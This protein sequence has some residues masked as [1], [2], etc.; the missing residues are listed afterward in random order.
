MTL[1]R[2]TSEQN[3]VAETTFNEEDSENS[4]IDSVDT[5]TLN[6]DENIDSDN[7]QEAAHEQSHHSEDDP[8]TRDRAQ[9]NVDGSSSEHLPG[10]QPT[11]PTECTQGNPHQLQS[12]GHTYHVY[13]SPQLQHRSRAVEGAPSGPI[14]QTPNTEESITPDSEHNATGT[15]HPSSEQA[16]TSA[17]VSLDDVIEHGLPRSDHEHTASSTDSY[18]VAF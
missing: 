11:S 14:Q 8:P 15:R 16:S 1:C 10:V 4:T 2:S 5:S 6:Q 3:L 17:L 18:H 9:Y 12:D 7:D 13:R